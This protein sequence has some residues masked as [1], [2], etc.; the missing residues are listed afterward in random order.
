MPG[1]KTS[2]NRTNRRGRKLVRH[3]HISPAAAQSL[4]LLTLNARGVRNSETITEAQIVE[5]LIGAA[6]RKLDEQYQADADE[7]YEGG[8]L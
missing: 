6:W 7:T 5:E 4:R 1:T 8:V 3:L 2:G